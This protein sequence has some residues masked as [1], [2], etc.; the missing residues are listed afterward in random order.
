MKYAT[1]ELW[2]GIELILKARLMSEH[3]SL[4]FRNPGKLGAPLLG[5]W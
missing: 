4:T 2:D 5:R 1:V 3:W